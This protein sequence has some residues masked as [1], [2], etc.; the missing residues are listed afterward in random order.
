MISKTHQ[1]QL[2]IIID[3]VCEVRG[4]SKECLFKKSRKT[5]YSWSRFL[6]CYLADKYTDLSVKSVA[7]FYDLDRTTAHHGI[8][9]ITNNIEYHSDIRSE[10][11][12]ADRL[13]IER[14]DEFKLSVKSYDYT[15]PRI[16]E[17]VKQDVLEVL[18]KH[19][20]FTLN[21]YQ[22]YNL[23]AIEVD[24]EKV[25]QEIENLYNFK[26]SNETEINRADDL[27]QEIKNNI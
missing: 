12:E 21:N 26:F 25:K 9:F 24:K 11:K 13:L 18:T 17:L 20:N 1:N 3:V 6:L 5:I 2:E 15:N 10:V 4:I 19:T 7:K 8:K 14:F 22:N 16:V 23:E 27:I